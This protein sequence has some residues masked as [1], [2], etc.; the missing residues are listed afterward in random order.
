MNQSKFIFQLTPGVLVNT[1][2]LIDITFRPQRNAASDTPGII[3][4][5]LT[6]LFSIILKYF[7][8]IKMCSNDERVDVDIYQFLK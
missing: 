1:Y 3:D 7:L 6:I 8:L 5:H 2:R 4:N